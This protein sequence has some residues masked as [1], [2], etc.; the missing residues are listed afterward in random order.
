LFP[1]GAKDSPVEY[2]GSR[3]VENLANFVKENGKHQA[4]AYAPKEA[5][6]EEGDETASSEAPAASGD[7]HDEL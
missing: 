5:K 1:A 7:D 4:D 3:T 6:P 2:L